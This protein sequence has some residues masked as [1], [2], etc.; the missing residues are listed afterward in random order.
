MTPNAFTLTSNQSKTVGDLGNYRNAS[1]SGVKY[2]D[3]NANG[4]K[5]GAES[6]P[7]VSF[8]IKVYNDKPNTATINYTLTLVANPPA[9]S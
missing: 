3:T 5:D 4:A 1:L 6:G 9:K 2:E 8:T 7:S